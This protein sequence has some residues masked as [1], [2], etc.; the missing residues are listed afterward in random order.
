MMRKHLRKTKLTLL[1]GLSALAMV[2]MIG[3]K[4][5]K[6][7]AEGIIGISDVYLQLNTTTY[8][9]TAD[10]SVQLSDG[11]TAAPVIDSSAVTFGTKGVYDVVYK[12]EELEAVRKV[13]VMSAPQMTCDD[14]SVTFAE[15]QTENIILSGVQATDCFDAVLNVEVTDD[16]GFEAKYGD[17]TVSLKATDKA[18]NV[19]E[20]TRTVTV[21]RTGEP[22]FVDTVY[23]YSAT[24]DIEIAADLK[25][26]DIT[27]VKAGET[28]IP[29]TAYVAETDKLILNAEA[30]ANTIGL[31]EHD[32]FVQTELGYAS[33]DLVLTD[34]T[35]PV[36]AVENELPAGY[37]Y[38]AGD[39]LTLPSAAKAG[40]S[41]Q[42]LTVEYSLKKDGASVTADTENFT[43][44]L[45]A[46]TYEYSV[47]IT[48]LGGQTAKETYEFSV[49]SGADYD[50][51]IDL[52]D[53]NQFTNRFALI[54][55]ITLTQQSDT[56]EGE[57]GYYTVSAVAGGAWS[58][59]LE[60]ATAQNNDYLRTLADFN[61]Y[62]KITFR[63]YMEEL[64]N[65]YAYKNT[66][67]LDFKNG[68]IV[69]YDDSTDTYYDYTNVNELVNDG[70]INKWLTVEFSIEGYQFGFTN[71]N[72]NAREYRLA[73]C[74]NT[75]KDA[76]IT[77]RAAD[78]R[79]STETVGKKDTFVGL[80][81]V[82][83]KTSDTTFDF[84]SDVYVDRYNGH[85]APE[86][87][88][89]AVTFGTQGSYTV[90]YT[91]KNLKASRNVII[92]GVPTLNVGTN[93][94]LDYSEAV[95]ENALL[96][97]VMASDCFGK[98]LTVT[99]DDDGGFIQDGTVALGTFT[100]KYS[101]T[102][103]AGQTVSGSR[104]VTVTGTPDP[105]F[106]VSSVTYDYSSDKALTLSL[107]LKGKQLSSVKIGDTTLDA[108]KYTY[109]A[110]ILNFDTASLYAA[111]HTGS[112]TVTAVTTGGN[113]V[114]SLTLT[115][116]ELPVYNL[117]SDM[118]NNSLYLVGES[119]ALPK[120]VKGET[121]Q[122]IAIEYVLL[123]D[124]ASATFDETAHNISNAAAGDYT[125]TV[126]VKN[127]GNSEKISVCV[128]EFM[129]RAKADYD[130]YIE[131]GSG[132]F[133]NRMELVGNGSLTVGD[134]TVGGVNSYLA[135]TTDTAGAWYNR[136]ELATNTN[137][138]YFKS[139]SDFASYKTITAMMYFTDVTNIYIWLNGSCLEYAK[140]G[141]KVYDLENEQYVSYSDMSQILNKWVRVEIP[142]TSYDINA[143]S[144]RFAIG[145]GQTSAGAK[146][147][148]TIYLCDIQFST[149][150]TV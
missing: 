91:Y 132:Q 149:N 114:M 14:L 58:N 94:S 125:F 47:E 101:A 11:S 146:V 97:N 69:L 71:P 15:A 80:S 111:Y 65:F 130:T 150:E 40:D 87:D 121:Y 7:K 30:L 25:G 126:T 41:K 36:Y 96:Q 43:L 22:T 27:I 61:S 24:T 124:G 4:S 52:G 3:C 50:K 99:I 21:N 68:G 127:V 109:E 75:A 9:F 62:K 2:A 89:S 95:L 23:D 34:K 113:A 13:Y 133:I 60:I 28:V 136:F 59:R 32:I 85:Q 140:G 53:S 55:G 64:I 102:D 19:V 137:N 33:F 16:G 83:L 66:T 79:F 77:F 141:L 143:S 116:N 122:N 88:A 57:T 56:Y 74:V 123:K 72:T 134:D 128:Y 90:Q 35:T 112:F 106:N 142:I 107:S 78:F 48:T 29:A 119:I 63:V 82:Y 76:G 17:Y 67:G 115:D 10:V 104:T 12:Y 86:Y 39:T 135:F 26:G 129:V 70:K 73:I 144:K 139:L 20:D 120:A 31:G 110:G 6:P 42:I 93:L 147:A 44:S 148:T 118:K 103:A 5:N 84:L 100:V 45:E 1:Y 92:M 105:E 145:A 37:V 54:Q 108:S 51:I 8:D 38:K 49:L 46:G 81:D 117:S 131:T 98:A 138:N 18:G